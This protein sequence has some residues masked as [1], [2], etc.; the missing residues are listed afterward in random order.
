MKLLLNV[1][2]SNFDQFSISLTSSILVPKE[3]GL[4]PGSVINSKA[5]FLKIIIS[6]VPNLFLIL[7]LEIPKSLLYMF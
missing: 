6:K 2:N 4:R 7:T 3:R 1:L 5:Y